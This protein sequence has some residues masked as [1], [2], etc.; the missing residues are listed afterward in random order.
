VVADVPPA[1]ALPPLPPVALVLPGADD[2]PP[3]PTVDALCA[4]AIDPAPT[5]ITEAIKMVFKLDI[6]AS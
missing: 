6:V 4:N 1:A 5:A 3:A 2:A